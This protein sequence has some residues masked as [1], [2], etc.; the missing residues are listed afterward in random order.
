MTKEEKSKYDKEYRLK[1]LEKRIKQGR[2]YYHKNKE[3]IS[4]KEKLK[5]QANPEKQTER[6][7]KRK[8]YLKEYAYKSEKYI[9]DTRLKRIY[10]ISLDD[11]NNLLISQ[12]ECC[13]ICTKHKSEFSK[14]LAVDH[15]HDTGQVRGLLCDLCNRGLGMFRDNP[16]L[17]IKANE[18]LV[19]YKDDSYVKLPD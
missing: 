7:L 14:A 4:E 19:S 13:K 11:Y 15:N 6:Y 10:N 17:L 18:Y 12:N 5:R 9:K 2:D 16:L 8:E 1:N 3:K